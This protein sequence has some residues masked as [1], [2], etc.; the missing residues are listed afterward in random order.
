M[1][2]ATGRDGKQ[3][4]MYSIPFRYIFGWL[5]TID[6]SKVNEEAREGVTEY[7]RQCYD[8]LFDHFAARARFVEEKQKEIDRQLTVVDDAKEAFRN[9]KNV[10]ADAE[11]ELKKLRSLTMDDY[12]MER[13]Q[14][15]IEF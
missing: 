4:D 6:T 14:L 15:K 8:A 2:H 1:I 10:L 12:D 9:A 5:F 3:Y 11:T 7:K 13:R